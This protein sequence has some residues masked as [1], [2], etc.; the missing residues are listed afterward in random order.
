M[1]NNQIK[2]PGSITD[3]PGATSSTGIRKSGTETTDQSGWQNYPE[4]LDDLPEMTEFTS[5]N[6]E[7]N[8]ND[9]TEEILKQLVAEN[10]QSLTTEQ[11]QN[12]QQ[13]H[14]PAEDLDAEQQLAQTLQQ[15]QENL[16][17]IAEA[18]E[19]VSLTPQ[20]PQSPADNQRYLESQLEELSQRS[21]SVPQSYNHPTL[22]PSAPP[23]PM[24]EL[25]P[26]ADEQLKVEAL[27]RWL[28]KP[29]PDKESTHHWAVLGY[30]AACLGVALLTYTGIFITGNY[31]HFS[32]PLVQIGSLVTGSSGQNTAFSKPRPSPGSTFSSS[33]HSK[34]SKSGTF[35]DNNTI[36]GK[37]GSSGT[38]A[39]GGGNFSGGSGGGIS[40]KTKAISTA[41]VIASPGLKAVATDCP[42]PEI[43]LSALPGGFSKISMNSSCHANENVILKYAGITF[44]QNFNQDGNFSF[45]LDAFAGEAEPV[46]FE[47]KNGKQ[48]IKKLAL[49]DMD[50]VSK[51]AV[52]WDNRENVNLHAFEYA[53]RPNTTG[54]VWEQNPRSY[55][56]A[57]Q[58]VEALQSGRGF[59]STT[60]TS[61][62]KKSKRVEV[63]TFIH[64]QPEK[65]GVIKLA[66]TY[67]TSG[68]HLN[69][70][71]CNNNT[72]DAP[73]LS[74]EITQ[75][76][77]NAP[78]K[79][80]QGQIL[81]N[82]CP[83]P[84]KTQYITRAVQDLI[85]T[86]N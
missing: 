83:A 36:T 44:N 23:P 79:K 29:M 84:G 61:T 4:N 38:K 49:T 72:A 58:K 62:D 78:L 31:K 39:S 9:L 45:V 15:V 70:V 80:E 57:L 43:S 8:Q 32:G 41:A 76:L 35:T 26:Q 5:E 46:Q 81:I 18:P 13:P 64:S 60:S 55:N 75:L 68:S 40:D 67:S 6:S 63:Y 82:N 21:L 47:F 42:V 28:D 19:Q 54:H 22:S 86:E 14:V 17:S 16:N 37:A 65:S 85:L 50:T 3:I 12:E 53:S 7:E 2:N 74:Y 33:S 11:P 25:M 77:K 59:L 1:S 73:Y 51:I 20:T 56:N 10:T 24:P 69:T 52:V 71:S 66:L 27:E 48:L 30:A 34:N